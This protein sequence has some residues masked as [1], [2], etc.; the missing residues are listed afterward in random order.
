MGT[1][2]IIGAGISAAAALG[3]SAMNSYSANMANKW[4]RREAEK[5]RKWQEEQWNKQNEYNLPSNQV[6]RL[7]DAGLN[8]NLILGSTG[9]SNA[10]GSFGNG[11]QASQQ[12][13]PQYGD[14]LKGIGSALEMY[15]AFKQSE[16]QIELNKALKLKAEKEANKTESETIGINWQNDFNRSTEEIQKNLLK[17]KNDLQVSSAQLNDQTKSN[18]KLIRGQIRAQTDLLTSQSNLNDA[19]AWYKWRTMDD[20]IAQVPAQTRKIIADAWYAKTM[21][22]VARLKLPY[23]INQMIFNTYV[24]MKQGQKLDWDIGTMP[25]M[26]LVKKNYELGYKLD[27]DKIKYHL[28]MREGDDKYKDVPFL[29]GL[30]N[31]NLEYV[32][33]NLKVW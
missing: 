16:S 29:R 22:D 26:K 30:T 20:R 17:T 10:A 24:A 1:A 4:N 33:D 15:Q 3:G 31:R 21:A 27:N 6:Q 28:D 12:V 5:N 13:S 2:A 25:D 18:L 8:P 9:V 14:G 7:R 23:E 11:A 19:D 32:F